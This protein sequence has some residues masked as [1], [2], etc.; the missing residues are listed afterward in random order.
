MMEIKVTFFL[1]KPSGFCFIERPKNPKSNK[2]KNKIE[3][4]LVQ[5]DRSLLCKS[6]L[7]DASEGLSEGFLGLA[8]LAE[9]SGIVLQLYLWFVSGFLTVH[10]HH[11]KLRIPLGS[12]VTPL[13]VVATC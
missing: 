11:S 5:H 13:G 7:G 8:P 2:Q 4:C 9:S 1:S 10:T 6:S 12:R 3:S